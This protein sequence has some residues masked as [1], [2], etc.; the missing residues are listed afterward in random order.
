[1]VKVEIGGRPILEIPG[2]DIGERK[3]NKNTRLTRS[4]TNKD[5][6]V[7]TDSSRINFNWSQSVTSRLVITSDTDDFDEEILSHYKEEGFQ[8]WYMPYGGDKAA[9][10]KQ[11]QHLPDPLELG[12]TYAIVAYGDAAALVLESAMRPMPKLCAV[13]A[14]YPPYMP[15]TTANFPPSLNL[16]IHLAA[17]Q[18]FGTRHPRNYRYPGTQSGFAESDLE[19]YDKPAA[20]VA[21]SRTLATLRRGFGI[22]PD[23]ESV[24]D[25]HQRLRDAI[26]EKDDEDEVDELMKTMAPDCAV[27][28]VPTMTG[29]VGKNRLRRFYSE[30]F[31]K[32]RPKEFKTK[33]LSRT[34]GTDRIVDEMLVTFTHN[35]EMPW[36][37]P[38]VPPTGKEV[39]I[40]VV[41][42]V[43]IRG[44]KICAENVH[45][46]QASALLQ[47]GLLDP[48][49]VPNS[50]KTKDEA[51]REVQHL[52]VLGAEA[53]KK[54]TDE[55]KGRS[56]RLI[57]GW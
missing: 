54:V 46:D 10:Q 8:I 20:R 28:H 16:T 47:V 11:L 27:N 13:V 57:P 32:S 3:I 9:Y 52:P 31:S 34:V 17:D 53:A 33:L 45:W 25:Y 26:P 12:E 5:G 19:E 50:F 42:V 30:F 35:I 48:K 56:N 18:K 14:Y 6:S 43:A 37:L 55:E 36:I 29:G 23:L 39:E 41:V 24:W 1:M 4:F 2:V 22:D 49:Y 7:R 21:W 51:K 40:V 15:K 44:D 38:G